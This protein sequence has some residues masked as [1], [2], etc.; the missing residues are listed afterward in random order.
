MQDSTDEV[1]QEMYEVLN[2]VQLAC[3]T[4]VEILNDLLCFDKIEGG[5]LELHKQEV[6][7]IRFLTETCRQF[8]GEF[9]GFSWRFFILFTNL[10]SLWHAC[11]R[12]TIH[13]IHLSL[14]HPLIN[15]S[16]DT[17]SHILTSHMF[18]HSGQARER[19]V[20]LLIDM[21]TI[22]HV[23]QRGQG[24]D[25]APVDTLALPHSPTHSPTL[26]PNPTYSH[27]PS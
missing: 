19:G 22:T 12:Y 5:I 25:D 24:L 3:N 10:S 20:K 17:F 15:P 7:V 26:L 23:T 4:S 27:K 14:F 11:G 9:V 1:E 13:S 2:D 8:T 16:S 21:T 18:T 6:P